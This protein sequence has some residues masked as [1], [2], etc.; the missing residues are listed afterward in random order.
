MISLSLY[1]G[2][3]AAICIIKDGEII[4]K[5]VK[6]IIQQEKVKAQLS[7]YKYSDNRLYVSV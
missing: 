3:N 1:N 2:H 5:L 4:L 6:P 7:K